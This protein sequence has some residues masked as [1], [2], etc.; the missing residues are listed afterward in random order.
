MATARSKPTRRR[1]TRLQE[2]AGD[3]HQAEPNLVQLQGRLA[4]APDCKVL[5]SGDEVV[6]FRLIVA[7]RPAAKYGPKVDTIDCTAWSAALRRRAASWGPGD[8]LTVEGR[9]RRRFWRSPQGP[10]SRY[11]VEVRRVSRTAAP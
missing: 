3:T 2:A 1:A 8:L 10:R 7:R 5:P 4:A 11:D 6:T 9:L